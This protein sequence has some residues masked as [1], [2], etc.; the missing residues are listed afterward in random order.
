MHVVELL[1]PRIDNENY[2][3]DADFTAASIRQ[4]WDAGYADTMRALQ[5]AAWN[6]PS[7][8]L[9]GVIMHEPAPPDLAPAK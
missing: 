2:T 4:R 8:P 9:E 7:D 3:K 6:D 5:R 1:A